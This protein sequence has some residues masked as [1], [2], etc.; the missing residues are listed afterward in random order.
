[1]MKFPSLKI[2]QKLSIVIMLMAL[3]TTPLVYFYFESRNEQISSAESEN[4]GLRYL[5]ELRQ[6]IEA[7]TT[8]R[9]ASQAYLSGDAS[10]RGAVDAARPMM[11]SAIGKVDR[12]DATVGANWDTT[13][14]WQAIR[15]SWSALIADPNLDART[16]AQRHTT[17]IDLV[18]RQVRLVSDKS[19]LTTDPMLDTYYMLDALVSGVTPTIDH[20]SQLRAVGTGAFARGQ[21]TAEDLAQVQLLT[22]Q[23]AANIESLD[24]T[25][26]SLERYSPA[27]R[28]ALDPAWKQAADSARSVLQLAL[29]DVQRPQNSDLNARA[30]YEKSGKAVSDAFLLYD[31]IGRTVGNVLDARFESLNRQKYVQMAIVLVVLA[32]ASALVLSI[33]RGLTRQAGSIAALFTE[34]GAGNLSAR[35][36]VHSN[37]ELGT[38][39]EGLNLM[40]D[41]TLTLIESREEKEKIQKSIMK[42]LD[43]VS[44]VAAG[45]LTKDA[46]VNSDI[47][48]AIADSF[49]YML[50]ELRQIISSVQ[51]TTSQVAGSASQVQQTASQ[52]ALGS[53][54]QS[55]QIGH[56]SAAIAEMAKSIQQ[57][58]QSASSAAKIAKKALQDAQGG[59]TTVRKT[60]EGMNAIRGRVQ[61]TSKR[62]KRL[63]ESSQEIVEIVRLIGDIADRTGIL[64][65]NAS[66]QASAAGE[67]GKGFATV[68]EE[69]ERLA[70]RAAE[71]AKKITAII[72]SVQ[73]DTSE[74]MA[75]MEETTREVVAGSQSANEAG[76]RL[77]DIEGVSQQIANLIAQISQASQQQAAGSEEVSRN[78]AGITTITQQTASGAK[79]T[80]ESTRRLAGLAAQL[81]ESISRFKL[82]ESA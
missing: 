40:L 58:S 21:A 5:T 33:S 8:H 52:L 51:S 31:Q 66:I 6:V 69:V 44:G 20:L 73:S 79:E 74:A 70:V 38:M 82:P 78:V 71:S 77:Q 43:E 68:A 72:K 17:L 54:T 9:D 81:S 3:P 63:G 37:D 19:R 49:N 80:E 65:L 16:S 48:G 42:L 25:L 46:E 15:G 39:A 26:D 11:T 64:A 67:A 60:I 27:A 57:V 56:A 1:M 36:E 53:E 28:K 32:I 47:T 61:E 35:A 22:R 23:L 24:R 12:I 29:G 4:N 75:A 41:N 7:L 50:E 45:D 76:Q 34:I 62:I 30:Y 59:A 55:L 18:L 13:P 14:R 10:L 2:W